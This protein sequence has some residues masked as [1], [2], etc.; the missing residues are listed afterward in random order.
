[1]PA[2]NFLPQLKDRCRQFTDRL[3]N[4]GWAAQHMREEPEPGVDVYVHPAYVNVDLSELD[5]KIELHHVEVI[6][7]HRLEC[8]D[9]WLTETIEGCAF[10]TNANAQMEN[11]SL[12]MVVCIGRT[13]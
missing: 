12:V 2:E 5:L 3:V 4:T 1:M 11:E 10:M 7:V 8:V 13:A 6:D 9:A